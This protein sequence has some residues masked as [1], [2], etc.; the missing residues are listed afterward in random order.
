M[1]VYW[2]GKCTGPVGFVSEATNDFNKIL[3]SCVNESEALSKALTLNNF[4]AIVDCGNSSRVTVMGL[5]MKEHA[6]HTII[7]Q[8]NKQDLSLTYINGVPNNFGLHIF[9]PNK[10]FI[11]HNK[12]FVI[13]WRE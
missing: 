8:T 10:S 7:E 9:H 2:H 1:C 13:S 12:S 5:Q 3:S 4:L 6:I 11:F